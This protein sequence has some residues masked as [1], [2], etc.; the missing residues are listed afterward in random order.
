MD[1]CE[2]IFVFVERRAVPLLERDGLQ[3]NGL[4]ARSTYK[5]CWRE[6]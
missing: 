3:G 5:D 1:G 6:G 4:A 2:W